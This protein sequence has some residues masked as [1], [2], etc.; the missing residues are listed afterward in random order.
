M[1]GD[2]TVSLDAFAAA[3]RIFASGEKKLI[4]AAASG[5][6]ADAPLRDSAGLLTWS[7]ANLAPM[8]R[9]LF[10]GTGKGLFPWCVYFQHRGGIDFRGFHLHPAFCVKREG[11]TFRGS[12]VDYDISSQFEEAEIHVARDPREM[13]MVARAVPGTRDSGHIRIGTLA[14]VTWAVS[15]GRFALPRHFWQFAQQITL[16]GEPDP[17][18]QR[19][20]DRTLRW[21]DR[22]RRGAERR[23]ALEFYRAAR[24]AA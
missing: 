1:C 15:M 7:M 20:A 21:I 12:T 24:R 22:A 4:V 3:K 16:V 8:C 6:S 19:L 11:L 17:D 5:V 2:M 23:Q 18:N 14:L 9:D 13:A 10:W